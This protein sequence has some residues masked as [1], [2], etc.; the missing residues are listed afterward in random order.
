[1]LSLDSC[2]FLPLSTDNIQA[3]NG[4]RQAGEGLND[5]ITRLLGTD[6]ATAN[7]TTPPGDS[8]A[9]PTTAALDALLV[10]LL[11]SGSFRAERIVTQR[12]LA[13]LAHAVAQQPGA[14]AALMAAN[15][16]FGGR[17]QYGS[18]AAPPRQQ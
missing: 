8:P 11:G 2:G 9:P 16:V 1:M 3:L 4:L 13:I 14:E 15:P 10:N 12:F 18:E 17:V 6:G 5:V 7:A